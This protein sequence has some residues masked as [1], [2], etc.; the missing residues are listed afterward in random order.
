MIL[1]I[2]IDRSEAEIA[3]VKCLING[4]DIYQ[5]YSFN[6]SYNDE[7]INEIVTNDL[8]AKNYYTPE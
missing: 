5:G 3:Q 1:Q 2:I 6:I 7:Q 8:I 4:V